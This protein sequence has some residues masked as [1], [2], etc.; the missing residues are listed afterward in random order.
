[1]CEGPKPR[2]FPHALKS[3]SQP[4]PPQGNASTFRADGN[5]WQ[6]ADGAQF[7]SGCGKNP[8]GAAAAPTPTPAVAPAVDNSMEKMMM[9]QMM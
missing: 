4:L 1:M 8:S 3:Q 2:D 6:N 5:F 7:C 9:M